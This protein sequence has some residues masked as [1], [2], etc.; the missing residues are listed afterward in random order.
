[1]VEID[2]VCFGSVVVVD[3]LVKVGFNNFGRKGLCGK[4]MNCGNC[5]VGIILWIGFCVIDC[6][7]L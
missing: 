2:G 5:V 3:K 7:R 1:M 4:S 6:C